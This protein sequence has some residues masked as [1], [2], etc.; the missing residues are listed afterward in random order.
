MHKTAL[1]PNGMNYCLNI[2]HI[3]PIYIICYFPK[4]SNFCIDNLHDTFFFALHRAEQS[5]HAGTEAECKNVLC[6]KWP[7]NHS[8]FPVKYCSLLT[9]VQLTFSTP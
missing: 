3:P 8:K 1:Y 4:M 2:Y 5:V 9:V 7:E 6:E